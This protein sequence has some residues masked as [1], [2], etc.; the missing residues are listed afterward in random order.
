MS[1]FSMTR[2]NYLKL[3]YGKVNNDIKTLSNNTINSVG[4]TSY[5]TAE[6]FLNKQNNNTAIENAQK[7]LD[8]SNEKSDRNGWQRFWDTIGE[9][10]NDVTEGF[11]NFGDD[12]FDFTVYGIGE[13]SG[14]EEWAYDLASYD[15]QAQVIKA[16]N[17]INPAFYFNGDA[18]TEEF[19][20]GWDSESARAQ[21]EK[22]AS[23]SLWNELGDKGH[24]FVKNLGQGIGYMVPSIVAGVLTGGASTTA[25]VA[26]LATTGVG[27]FTG[28][29]ADAYEQSGNF[30]K[31]M[32]SGL[33]NVAVEV[34]TELLVGKTLGAIGAG[35]GKIAG[36]IGKNSA[37]SFTKTMVK[38]M[39]EEGVEEAVAGVLQPVVDSIYQG[40]E[41]FKDE[42]GNN[43]Y[44]N[45][46][47]WLGSEGVLE[48]GLLGASMGGIL[49]GVSVKKQF[50]ALGKEGVATSQL[51]EE[52]R[53]LYNKL[54]KYQK[55][56][57][58]YTQICEKISENTAKIAYY[59]DLISKSGNKTHIKNLAKL[60]SD[61]VSFAKALSKND[62]NEINKLIDSRVSELSTPEKFGT[63]NLF[64][65][66]QERFNTDYELEFGDTKGNN[67]YIDN[68]NK[69]IVINENI[70]DE[71]A[72][73]LAHEY[74]GHAIV[75]GSIDQATRQ[76]IFDSIVKTDWFKKYNSKLRKAYVQEDK[77]YQT[78]QTNEEKKKYWQSEVVNNYLEDLFKKGN[79]AKS[80][81]MINDVFLRNTLLNRLQAFFSKKNNLNL[82]KNN[83]FLNEFT[84]AVKTVLNSTNKNVSRA[85]DKYLKGETLNKS[86]E[87]YLNKYRSIFEHAKMAYSKNLENAIG[88][89]IND[90]S[91]FIKKI[92]QIRNNNLSGKIEIENLDLSN[93]SK[94][95]KGHLDFID[96]SKPI[97]MENSKLRKVMKPFNKEKHH[98]G[99]TAEN[100]FDAIKNINNPY[101]ITQSSINPNNISFITKT[102]NNQNENILVAFNFEYKLKKEKIYVNHIETIYGVSEVNL[103]K[104]ESY[105]KLNGRNVIYN[106]RRGWFAL[107]A[108]ATSSTNSIN[109]NS[110]NINKKYSKSLD[111]EENPLTESQ[112]RYF[113]DSKFVDEEGNLLILYHGTDNAGFMTFDNEAGI[114][115]FTPDYE[116][117]YT[118]TESYNQVVTRNFKNADELIDW[119]YEEGAKE[120]GREDIDVLPKSEALEEINEY[121]DTL[122]KHGE[123]AKELYNVSKKN[124]DKCDYIVLNSEYTQPLPYTE[125]NLIKNFIPDLQYYKNLDE[126]YEAENRYDSENYE[127]NTNNIY[128][129]YV[130]ATNPLIVNCH[131]RNFTNIIFRGKNMQTDE[132]AK[133]VKEEGKYDGI[134][135]KNVVDNGGKDFYNELGMSDVYVAFDSK[136]IKAVDN[137]NPTSN[138]DIRY[139]KKLDVAKTEKS[140]Y[141]EIKQEEVSDEFR[142]IQEESRREL[143]S[144]SWEERSSRN[145]ETLRRRLSDNIK[146]RLDSRG[147]NSS[148]SNAILLKSNK[149]TEFRM[150]ENIDGDLFHDCF[151]IARTYLLNGELVDLHDNYNDST[152]YLSDDGLSGFAITKNGDLVSV[153]NLDK[154][155]KGF[156][157]AISTIVK[158][159]AKTLDCYVSPQQNLQ[160]MYERFF[161][162]KTASVMDYNMEYDHDD[163]AKNHNNPK[164]AF[165]VNTNKPV[166][167]RNFDKDSYD[168]AQAYQQSFVQNHQVATLS[169]PVDNTTTKVEDLTPYETNKAQAIKE[170]AQ[171]KLG[172]T[173]NLKNTQD[174]YDTIESGIQE[175]F[176]EDFKIDNKKLKAR[177]LFEEYN[178]AKN[179]AK[180]QNCKK[181]V[182]DIL[183]QEVFDNVT[184]REYLQANGVNVENAIIEGTDLMFE[185]LNARAV[186]SNITKK[187][188]RLN[189]WIGMYKEARLEQA[190]TFKFMKTLNTIRNN[191]SKHVAKYGNTGQLDITSGIKGLFY[192]YFSKFRFTRANY[193]SLTNIANLQKMIQDGSFKSLI[194]SILNPYN[195]V[196]NIEVLKSQAET[197]L[198]MAEDLANSLT[199]GQRH[200]N[201]DQILAFNNLNKA[202]YKLYKDYTSGVLETTREQASKLISRAKEVSSRKS[203]GK[204]KSKIRKATLDALSPKEIIAEMVGGTH[205]EEFNLIYNDL[206]R[207]PYE[208]QIDKYVDFL[209]ERDN[210]I[211]EIQ[212]EINKKVK[213][214]NLTVKKYVLFQF[215]LNTLSPDNLIRMK[216]SNLTYT[217][218]GIT[219]KIRFTELEEASNKYITEA[220]KN[221]LNSL[222]ALYNGSVKAYVESSSNKILGFS[223]SRNDY[224][225]IVASEVVKNQDLSNPNKVRYNINA[226]NNG[227]LKKLSNKNTTIEINVNP[228]QLFDSYIESMTITGEIGLES[229]KLNRLFQIKDNNG[230]S[231]ASV[232]NEFIP[233][234]KKTYIPSIFNKLIGNTQTIERSSLL[235]REVGRFAT[236]TLGLNIRSML[237]QIGSFFTAWEKVGIGTGFKVML[238][239]KAIK[240]I[241]KNRQ[242]L[243]D[244]NPV[245]KLRTYENGYVR[246]ATLS[247]GAGQYAGKVMKTITNASLKG[248]EAMD[249]LTC[250]ATFA[251][252]E[253]YVYKT[254]GYAVGTDENLK[255]ANEM[256]S[257]IILETQSNSDR[258][259]MSRIRSGEKGWLCKNIF[260]LFQSDAQNKAGL[261]FNIS[262]DLKNIKKDIIE[263]EA[264]IKN[265]T[266]P[267]AK[268]KL[269]DNRN[270]LLNARTHSYTRLRAYATGLVLSAI[271]VALADKLADYI[272]DKEDPE[273]TELSELLMNILSNTTVEWIPYLNQI[274]NFIQYDGIEISAFENFNDLLDTIKGFADGNVSTQDFMQAII[275][276]ASVCGLPL[277]NLNKLVQGTISNFD[278][279]AGIR[280]QS[281]F[282]N[283][284]Q[285]Y[286]GRET[287][288]Y[289]AKGNIEKAEANTSL[290]Y[291]IYKFEATD[292]FISEI[293]SLKR[294]GVSVRIKNLP[295]TITKEEGEVYTLTNEEMIQFKKI[296][297]EV[298]SE[299]E[300]LYKDLNYQKLS[301]EE[302]GKVISKLADLYY[303]KAKNQVLKLETTSK[304][305][306]LTN[307]NIPVYDYL[308]YMTILQNSLEN[309]KNR[310]E[311][312]LKEINK[313]TS[314]SK[315]EKLLLVHLMGYSISEASQ[316][317]LS[318]YL[319]E[320]G[321]SSEEMEKWV[322]K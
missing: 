98:H 102:I 92:E 187:I 271:A 263:V 269:E 135:F 255:L 188:N 247:A 25:Q 95:I 221:D 27:A 6:M 99:I 219:K 302:K 94:L 288:E 245:F 262:N 59:V 53:S 60:L 70:S 273:D 150:Y 183:A 319:K 84:K 184:Y 21:I 143:N 197:I 19:W 237:K 100:I 134:I 156:L 295:S 47:F 114:H 212:K 81:K 180:K 148:T 185:L 297:G 292:K 176:G 166:E 51:L 260:G 142:R 270:I 66:L 42:K 68:K 71:Y 2:S 199:T 162:F 62:T 76:K 233:E 306:R 179:S 215:Y 22:T 240:R 200:L 272:Y 136:Q 111:S 182:F 131:G 155:K 138:D 304:L 264:K 161:D 30:G 163:I 44:L 160:G 12:I 276:L 207:K 126:N 144:S 36:T 239:P 236:A 129:V 39:F 10:I 308:I 293:T 29:T 15:W 5:E 64:N 3:M 43:I 26:S 226:L 195:E 206:Y 280:Y 218:D 9:T 290:N 170:G 312:L 86:E 277:N 132:I 231:F 282:Y 34:G 101:M 201:Y 79:T 73:V 204:A 289:I 275:Q 147:Y 211:K 307:K 137:Y 124:Y 321:F 309:S 145:N 171:E 74:L 172:K 107:I 194:N 122:K 274:M 90:K 133:I 89:D 149:N 192:S 48:Q 106:K 210:C 96:L 80:I 174:V 93:L 157:S 254:H 55:T 118:Y 130:N 298:N 186:D 56:D 228:I 213:V 291:S 229:Q 257:E 249:R 189:K 115:F 127:R 235:D 253:E 278:P 49:G 50:N 8:E 268:K 259:A 61:P 13:L 250:Y 214:G 190:E 23:T 313:I 168:Q 4:D 230:D 317:L 24:R 54:S 287:N 318:H 37:D 175:L 120:L 181:F 311:T 20:T 32:L 158:E 104:Y 251:L 78:L 164:V 91:N 40:K 243:K 65:E 222:F 316:P 110:E 296:Y 227:R 267:E 35:T 121:L 217:E 266:D 165:M 205:T 173:I 198:E 320:L 238:N 178:L 38:T 314:L 33:A 285:S 105:N 242:Y 232:V 75:D 303:D 224:Y 139:S 154:T 63:R 28:G 72:G 146:G 152:C 281:L 244:N 1:D 109:D 284:S 45:K 108:P 125:E 196:N 315:K 123:K 261:I 193:L 177:R 11:L 223:V 169:T 18:F 103:E 159:R 141:N 246:G 191:L 31:S 322:A 88:L 279:E 208:K 87:G 119:W 112:E 241:F 300:K 67:A 151:E 140:S 225:P 57:K 16:T 128:K 286:L 209:K 58:K 220:E 234:A 301:L 305:S 248:L 41:A 294:N 69:K 216:N 258:I 167:T 203:T 202:V 153:F 116:I 77:N 299:F 52:N 7:Y 17:I 310:R 113:K 265:T 97:I 256:F 83:A 283:M 85:L 82:V 117:A 252:C 46:E 14:N